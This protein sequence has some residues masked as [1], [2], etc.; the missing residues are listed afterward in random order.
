VHF[1]CTEHSAGLLVWASLKVFW[2][3]GARPL[4]GLLSF[5][6]IRVRIGKYHK[7]Y[8]QVFWSWIFLR[9]PKKA[10]PS[11]LPPCPVRGGG[12]G[13]LSSYCGGPRAY[14]PENRRPP[15][16]P[17]TVAGFP[18]A[19]RTLS[20]S[21]GASHEPRRRA[22]VCQ[23]RLAASV[24]WSRGG[25]GRAAPRLVRVRYS[26]LAPVRVFNGRAAK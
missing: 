14:H 4:R 11:P 23:A 21:Q 15:E 10:A 25:T 8:I 7:S 6:R 24:I 18:P 16:I 20:P 2:C 1:W 17:I 13:L 3:D 12:S 5:L 22:G 26:G 19:S 9:Y